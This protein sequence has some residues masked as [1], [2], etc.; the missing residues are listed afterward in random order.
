V[1]SVETTKHFQHIFLKKEELRVTVMS[2]FLAVIIEF[3]TA[4]T[5]KGSGSNGV[6]SLFNFGCRKRTVSP[7]V[8]LF[9]LA[10]FRLSLYDFMVDLFFSSR[11]RISSSFSELLGV[12][13]ES[14]R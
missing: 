2:L 10:R 11:L 3:L 1:N 9:G 14:G 12:E 6:D 7:R 13:G 8:M 5:R 4:T